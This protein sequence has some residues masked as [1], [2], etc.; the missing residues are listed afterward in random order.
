MPHHPSVGDVCAAQAVVDAYHRDTVRAFHAFQAV[1]CAVTTDHPHGV[2][3]RCLACPQFV[4]ATGAVKLY[5]F[6]REG[7]RPPKGIIYDLSRFLSTNLG[8]K[9]HIRHC[10]HLQLRLLVNAP[11]PA[12]AVVRAPP[13]PRLPLCHADLMRRAFG[14]L[15]DIAPP[16]WSGSVPSTG[17]A[18]GSKKRRASSCKKAS[19]QSTTPSS[20]RL[21]RE[22]GPVA[23]KL[24]IDTTAC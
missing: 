21:G 7:S 14:K 22:G 20:L 13:P 5:K 19:P 10:Q 15:V 9:S 1:A 24:W 8:T 16:R 11:Q 6:G 18:P 3:I 12:A 17:A 23:Q 4:S 2:A